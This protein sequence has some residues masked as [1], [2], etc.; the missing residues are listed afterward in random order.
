MV[1]SGHVGLVSAEVRHCVCFPFFYVL[2]PG[3]PGAEGVG[4]VFALMI[5]STF[6]FWCVEMEACVFSCVLGVPR[7]VVRV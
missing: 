4:A 7:L 2:G 3:R 6:F 1:A 5:E